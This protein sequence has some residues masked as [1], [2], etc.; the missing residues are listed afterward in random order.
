MHLH[1]FP[2]YAQHRARQMYKIAGVLCLVA[3]VLAFLGWLIPN[4][5]LW[6]YLAAF[7]AFVNVPWFLDNGIRSSQGDEGEVRA[8]KALSEL[9]DRYTLVTNWVPVAD[10]G[11]VDLALFGPHGILVLEVKTYAVKMK[12]EGDQWHIQ[13]KNGS[14][15]PVK[16]FSRQ[17]AQN[18]KRVS[19]ALN[20]PATGVLVFND[21][22]NIQVVDCPVQ[23]L[24]RKELLD[25]VRSLSISAIKIEEKLALIRES[26]DYRTT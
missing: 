16:S 22:A 6:L 2:S 19:R 8:I 9:D 20:C 14:W 26:L 12:C 11:D 15:R 7:A 10:K 4:W 23:V 5:N 21:R 3:G 17:L 18:V 24:R 1:R 25:F 13:R